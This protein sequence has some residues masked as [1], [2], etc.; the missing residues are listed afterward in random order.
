VD[1]D[2]GRQT[3]LCDR[4]EGP[5]ALRHRGIWENWKNPAGEWVRTFAVLTTAA[6]KNGTRIHNRMPAILRP[7][8]YIRWLGAEPR[9]AR[10]AGAIFWP[11]RW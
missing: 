6:N 3:A 2:Q 11:R 7:E 4:H 5:I 1:G 10:I 8:D 9:P